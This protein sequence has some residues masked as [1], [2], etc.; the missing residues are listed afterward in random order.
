[1]LCLKNPPNIG[2]DKIKSQVQGQLYI[3][4][5]K[6]TFMPSRMNFHWR[7]I[8]FGTRSRYYHMLISKPLI[9]HQGFV[10]IS[11]SSCLK[12]LI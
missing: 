11:N 1:M 9:L 3:S 5:D 10:C 2:E 4:I 8:C 7:P 12:S 6:K